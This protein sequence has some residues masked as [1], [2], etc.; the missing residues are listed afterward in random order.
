MRYPAT[1]ETLGRRATLSTKVPGLGGLP[2][3][4]PALGSVGA[5]AP[6]AGSLRC[7]SRWGP[8]AGKHSRKGFGG[9]GRGG[10][11][12]VCCPDRWH[13]GAACACSFR[14]LERAR[15]RG[16]ARRVQV[17]GDPMP[18]PEFDQGRVDLGTDGHYRRAS[19]MEVTAG[20]G[21]GGTGYIPRQDDPLSM[22]VRVR[23]RDRRKQG[24]CVRVQGPIE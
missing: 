2:P 23:N 10:Q 16:L 17:A 22:E 4:L 24:L 14:R 9:R 21:C 12:S 8:R 3:A 6:P 20:G 1:K 7:L 11:G 19:R 18:R 15:P 13:G 5:L